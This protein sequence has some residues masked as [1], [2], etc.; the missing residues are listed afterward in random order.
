MG[1]S[2]RQATS[3]YK[4]IGRS[5]R[6]LVFAAVVGTWF[7]MPHQQLFAAPR[8][9]PRQVSHIRSLES[10]VRRAVVAEATPPDQRQKPLDEDIDPELERYAQIVYD[11][12]RSSAA[13]REQWN[14]YC[15]KYADGHKNPRNRNVP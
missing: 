15:D 7:R 14:F 8:L 3:P 2:Q 10:L 1:C 13:A 4:V 9:H 11:H 5:A 12:V 6:L